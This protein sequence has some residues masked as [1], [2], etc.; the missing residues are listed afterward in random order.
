V[1]MQVRKLG[2][3]EFEKDKRKRTLEIHY[4]ECQSVIRLGLCACWGVLFRFV[5]LSCVFLSFCR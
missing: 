1:A 5:G 3:A 2:K 4:E